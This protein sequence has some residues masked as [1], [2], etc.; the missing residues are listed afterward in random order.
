MSSPPTT[1]GKYQII[2]EIARSNDIVYEAYDPLMNRRVALKELAIPGGSTGTQK[3][4]RIKRFLREAKA[5][6]SLSHPNIMTVYEVGEEGGRHF[7]AMEFLDGHTL[8][9]EIDTHGSL[10]PDRA[11]EIAIEV[12]EALDF[13][14]KNGVVH[15]DIKPDNIQLLSDGRIKIT[16]F[17][18]ARLTFEPNI[19]MDGQVF[20]TPSY[21]SPEQVVGKDIDARSDIFSLGIVLYEMIAGQKPFTGDSVVAITYAI[22]NKEPDRPQNINFVVWQLIA[23][24]LDKSPALRQASANELREELVRA[25]A[26]S[27]S[28]VLDPPAAQ[29]GAF[30]PPTGNPYLTPYQPPA[31]Q[32]PPFGYP[33]NPYQPGT[34]PGQTTVPPGYMLPLPN[35]YP[36]PPRQPLIKAETK[37][38]LARIFV[39]S[40]LLGALIGLVIVGVW[41]AGQVYERMR[42]EAVDGKIKERMAAISQSIPMPER[43][44]A[45]RSLMNQ[46]RDPNTLQSA[47]AGLAEL[48]VENA[49]AILKRGDE[50]GAEINMREAI[51][52]DSLNPKWYEALGDFYM[53]S[54]ARAGDTRRQR[55]RFRQA[56]LA[57][58]EGLG[59]S[60]SG[61]ALTNKAADASY[62][63]AVLSQ[64]E[65]DFAGFDD[66]IRRAQT[67]ANDAAL[68]SR[69]RKLGEQS[70]GF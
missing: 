59:Y 29:P 17:G 58:E 57:Y 26:G 11:I 49:E 31:P 18:I 52:S 19:T 37:R 4:D 15:R 36:P 47:R 7:I 3:E 25:K 64:R 12:C 8:R 34:A 21:M 69:I 2:R 63:A 60:Q 40:M 38:F 22:M 1:L 66:D 27:A 33:Y 56:S 39:V 54:A 20:G 65:G 48:Y 35:Y 44:E 45:Y 67:L 68:L 10:S 41:S 42:S 61:E 30:A 50:T 13:S 23:K 5:A 14:H 32:P 53:K 46:L 43:I 51:N 16:D 55:D 9:N 24:A 62:R 28:L 6:G 70:P